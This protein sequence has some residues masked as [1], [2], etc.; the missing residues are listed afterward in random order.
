[1]RLCSEHPKEAYRSCEECKEY[2]FD[3]QSGKKIK[4]GKGFAKRSKPPDCPLCPKGKELG[5]DP[6]V[7]VITM[8]KIYSACKSLGVL[9]SK[10]ALLDQERR[11][12]AAFMALGSMDT[13]ES[14]AYREAA[15]R[16]RVGGF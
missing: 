16:A 6:S 14:K 12:A 13:F 1:M 5:G 3:T 11:L 7:W 10:G 4:E 15:L 9:P 2:V 8:T